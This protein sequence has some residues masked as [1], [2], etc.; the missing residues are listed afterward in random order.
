MGKHTSV[1]PRNTAMFGTG[2]ILPRAEKQ[3]TGL[4]F[5]AVAAALFESR[6]SNTIPK[7]KADAKKRPL[8]FLVGV[9]G[10]S[11]GL[12]TCHRHVFAASCRRPVRIPPLKY[13]TKKESG[14]KKAST[15]FFGRSG[16][17]LPRAKNVPPARFCGILPPPCSN[18]ATQIRYQKKKADAKSVHFLFWSEWRDSNPRPLGPEPSAIPN[19]ATPRSDDYYSGMRMKSQVLFSEKPLILF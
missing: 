13:D 3:S 6:R 16:G 12:K 19:F 2:G 7:K 5:A 17:I 11:R 1:Q 18:P 14:R 10:F 9:A 15:F 4:F 8:S